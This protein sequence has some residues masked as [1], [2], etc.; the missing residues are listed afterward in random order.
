MKSVF[1]VKFPESGKSDLFLGQSTSILR[2]IASTST[3]TDFRSD[4]RIDWYPT[5][6]TD[7]IKI[8]EF[9]DF[10][11]AAMNPAMIRASQHNHFHK[12]LFK[13]DKK[14]EKL[15]KGSNPAKQFIV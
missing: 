11:Q 5:D 6:L 15:V 2:F 9:F 3:S 13:M 4:E 1:K 7:R 10:W 12:I 8:E 14:D